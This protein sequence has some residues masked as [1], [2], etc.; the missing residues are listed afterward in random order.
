MSA[1]YS[2]CLVTV[3]E[4]LRKAEE[5]A[6]LGNF[7]MALVYAGAAMGSMLAMRDSLTELQERQNVQRGS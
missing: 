6:A 3:R 5:A 4:A 1:D 7:A 2:S